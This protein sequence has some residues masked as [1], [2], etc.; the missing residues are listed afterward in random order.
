[1]AGRLGLRRAHAGR[2][3]T[4][5]AIASRERVILVAVLAIAGTGTA[6]AVVDA[7]S[8][9]D[10]GTP[11]SAAASI[12]MTA[13][14]ATPVLLPEPAPVTES[15]TTSTTTAPRVTEQLASLVWPVRG[16]V[17]SEFAMRD[18]RPHEGL[19]I[20][21][22]V[23]TPIVAAWSGR[24]AFTGQQ[25]GYGNITL[26]DHGRGFTTAY[27]HQD[28]F[29]VPAGSFVRA[30]DVIGFVGC[31]GSCTGP[32][33]HFETRVRGVAVDPRRFLPGRAP[34]RPIDARSDR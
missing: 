12:A 10:V 14:P 11:R 27:P 32:H 4:R 23:G 26:I 22:P 24:V 34:S 18:G 8:L 25:S 1:M 33:L 6:A 31:S 30:G 19:D 13:G 7:R 17:T 21:A 16:Q 2:Y 9:A 28:A 3:S 5:P 29:A 20:S 15:T